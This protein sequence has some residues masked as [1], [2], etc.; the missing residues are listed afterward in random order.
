MSIEL[1]VKVV[2][3]SVNISEGQVGFDR[4]KQMLKQHVKGK[5]RS[6]SQQLLT[7]KV[8]TGE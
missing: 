8:T 5:E 3:V 7:Q 4:L 2:P 1:L 6:S